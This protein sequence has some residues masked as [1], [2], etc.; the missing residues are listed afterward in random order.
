MRPTWGGHRFDY[1]PPGEPGSD[2]LSPKSLVHVVW[3]N[4]DARAYPL[5]E[6]GELGE[7][8]ADEVGGRPVSVRHVEQGPAATVTLDDGTPVPG[9]TMYRE[10]LPEFYPMARLWRNPLEGSS[11][12]AGSRS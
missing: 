12:S 4:G 5:E 1:R 6:L 10:Y 7:L 9:I 3:I 2:G 8:L 11:S